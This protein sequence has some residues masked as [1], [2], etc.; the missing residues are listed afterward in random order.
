MVSA[1]QAQGSLPYSCFS[2]LSHLLL[3]TLIYAHMMCARVVINAQM[4][5]TALSS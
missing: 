3:L 4:D 5:N 1:L 2:H